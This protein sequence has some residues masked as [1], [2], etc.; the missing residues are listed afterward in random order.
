MRQKQKFEGDATVSHGEAVMRLRHPAPG[1][2]AF[3]MS[4]FAVGG[5]PDLSL[6]I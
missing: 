6:L 5:R 2:I 1:P 3:Q 4:V